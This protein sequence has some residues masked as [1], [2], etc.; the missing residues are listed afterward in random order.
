MRPAWAC[1]RTIIEEPNED[2]TIE[3]LIWDQRNSVYVFSCWA[4]IL[5]PVPSEVVTD[6][7][8]PVLGFWPN[9]AIPHGAVAE[10]YDATVL[11]PKEKQSI[12]LL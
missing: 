7:I 6:T 10:I 3:K 1:N 12:A 9:E 4:H 8:L 2:K 11:S 5:G